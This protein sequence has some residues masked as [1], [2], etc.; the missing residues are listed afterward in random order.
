MLLIYV[1][2]ISVHSQHWTKNRFDQNTCISHFVIWKIY[3][4]TLFEKCASDFDANEGYNTKEYKMNAHSRTSSEIETVPYSD[5]LPVFT[6]QFCKDFEFEDVQ[7]FLKDLLKP[8][9]FRYIAKE[10]SRRIKSIPNFILI[11]LLNFVRRKAKLRYSI[12]YGFCKIRAMQI[13]WVFWIV[14]LMITNGLLMTLKMFCGSTAL[15]PNN[16]WRH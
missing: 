2:T 16:I 13:S 1:T 7:H 5:I 4:F 11:V 9:E 10:V 3:S 8:E 14:L 6:P 12:C 15:L